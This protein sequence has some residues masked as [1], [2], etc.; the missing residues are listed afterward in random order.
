MGN[1][2]TVDVDASSAQTAQTILNKFNATLSQVE[3]NINRA[4]ASAS[5]GLGSYL[6]RFAIRQTL[7]GATR[8]VE[9]FFAVSIKQA[10]EAARVESLFN[11]Q[12]V[13]TS[14][15]YTTARRAAEEFH[16]YT[17]SSSAQASE[18]TAST[19][20]IA[21]RAG[22]TS[23]SDSLIQKSVADIV[24]AQGGGAAETI[25]ALQKLATG[26]DE[27]IKQL[28][29]KSAAEVQRSFALLNGELPKDLTEM[30]RAISSVNAVI[31][32]GKIFNGEAASH[33]ETV[34]G[35]VEQATNRWDDYKAG[36]GEAIL[37]SAQLKEVLD[38][39]VGSLGN[40]PDAARKGFRS[41]EDA[42]KEAE[43]VGA[44]K[45]IY[46]HIELGGKAGFATLGG[47]FSGDFLTGR[48][49]AGLDLADQYRDDILNR[50]RTTAEGAQAATNRETRN[51]QVRE[52]KQGHV[53]DTDIS[54][55]FQTASKYQ[56]AAREQ[57]LDNQIDKLLGGIE[58]AKGASERA[59]QESERDVQLQKS[60]FERSIAETNKTENLEQRI[61]QLGD[62]R[63]HVGKLPSNVFNANDKE[64]IT[65]RI[66]ADVRTAK[67][68]LDKLRADASETL[69]TISAKIKSQNP[70]VKLLGKTQQTEKISHRNLRNFK[71]PVV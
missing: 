61:K 50:D 13:A 58:E 11:A 53:S 48:G 22:L 57:F 56:G 52:L 45:S 59:R 5:Q 35:R 21:S 65:S 51:R 31:D 62:E 39:L 71:R 63:A 68:M 16:N 46:N 69:D 41:V 32:A 55:L 40:L 34:A 7:L 44:L 36:V 23:R 33:L 25:K 6:E 10:Q 24:A 3:Q 37:S 42:G 27:V 20:E 54:N 14:Q 43:Q 47:I 17:R 28:T 15:S 8:H 26:N 1:K 18:A 19:A 4:V 9:D 64:S 67:E 29:G 66:D 60:R 2:L 38:S 70:F 49:R 30:E 12:I